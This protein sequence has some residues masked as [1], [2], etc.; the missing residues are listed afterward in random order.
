MTAQKNL[1]LLVET[2]KSFFITTSRSN[3]KKNMISTAKIRSKTDRLRALQS[4]LTPQN[5]FPISNQ[6]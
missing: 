4:V 1:K 2:T 5:V 6:P 3:Q